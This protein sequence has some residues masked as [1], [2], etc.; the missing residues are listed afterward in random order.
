M[1]AMLAEDAKNTKKKNSNRA[2]GRSPSNGLEA[3]TMRSEAEKEENGGFEP[4]AAFMPWAGAKRRQSAFQAIRPSKNASLASFTPN[5]LRVVMRQLR[6]NRQKP[7]IF[8][9][10]QG[11]STGR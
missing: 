1:P 3:A 2:G 10:P 8:R 5:G 6:L 4:I 7:R 11:F 9:T